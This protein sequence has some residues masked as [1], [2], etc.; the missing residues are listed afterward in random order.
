MF[1]EVFLKI[2]TKKLWLICSVV[3]ICQAPL[4][5]LAQDQVKQYDEGSV[6]EG[7]FKNGL[8]NGLG[9]YTMPDGFKYEGEWKDDQIQGKGVARY[10]TGQ[11]YEGFFKQGVPNGEGTMT[12]SDGTKYKGTWLDGKMEGDGTLTMTDG[13]VFKGKFSKNNRSG[14]GEM[15]Y[16]DGSILKA[17]GKI[18][19]SRETE[20]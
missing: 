5:I 17:I 10:P 2:S 7:S 4:T 13:S 3:L 20:Y 6:Y 12:F 14:Y 11:I 15:N 8:R 1:L 18:M 9:K 19:K 16:T